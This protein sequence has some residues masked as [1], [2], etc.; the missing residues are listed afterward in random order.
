MHAPMRPQRP[1]VSVLVPCRNEDRHI[2]ATLSA[3]HRQMEPEGGLEILVVDG[4]SDDGTRA[5]LRRWEAA[6]PRIRVVDNPGRT[7]ATGLNA[8]VAA[9]RGE[10][11][12]RADAHTDYADDYVRSCVDVLRES[13]ADNVGGPWVARG[14]GYVSRAAAAVFDSRVVTGGGR[15]RNGEHEGPVES[16]YLGCWRREAM[17]RFGAFDE[18][19]VRNQ[20]DEHNLRIVRGG[21]TI[22]QSRRIRSWYHPRD[23]VT[24][25]FRQHAEYGYWKVAVIRKHGRP[26]SLRHL[27]PGAFVALLVLLGT[28]G[29]VWDGARTALLATSAL[30][31]AVVLL[32]SLVTAHRVD[33]KLLPILP[34]VIACHHLGYG[35]GFCVGALHFHLV[36]RV[37]AADALQSASRAAESSA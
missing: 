28:L 31:A 11:L 36:R 37:P 18:Q 16:V 7:V 21:G 4:M 14:S 5:I 20:D 19:L 23:T 30:Y 15:A 10:I 1:R 34:A 3:L 8:A 35:T 25:L 26:A 13:G 33:W 27:V 22:W 24:G 9:A 12:V 29:F 6:D 17:Q 2:D 32:T